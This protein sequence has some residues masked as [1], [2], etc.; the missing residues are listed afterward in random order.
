MEEFIEFVMEKQDE[1]KTHEIEFKEKTDLLIKLLTNSF[2]LYIEVAKKIH[3]NYKE[4]F[5]K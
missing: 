3:L 4:D 2:E 1:F 5:K